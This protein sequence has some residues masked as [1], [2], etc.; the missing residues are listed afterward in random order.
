MAE[1]VAAEDEPGEGEVELEQLVQSVALLDAQ[2]Q[3]ASS[4]GAADDVEELVHTLAAPLLELLEHLQREHRARAAAVQREHADAPATPRCAWSAAAGREVQAKLAQQ[5]R[6]GE[7]T[8]AAL[9]L[10]VRQGFAQAG[11]GSQG[12]A[13]GRRLPCVAAEPQEQSQLSGLVCG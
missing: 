2:R 13:N 4:G 11:V 1:G 6:R 8:L 7:L 9:A 10:K 5:L 12:A 3:D